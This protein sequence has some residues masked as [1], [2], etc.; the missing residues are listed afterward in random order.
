MAAANELLKISCVNKQKMSWKSNFIE[1]EH[2][3][4]TAEFNTNILYNMLEAIKYE[5]PSRTKNETKYY[6]FIGFSMALNALCTWMLTVRP[7]LN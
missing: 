6:L 7:A 4:F 3:G 2:F 5:K 1:N